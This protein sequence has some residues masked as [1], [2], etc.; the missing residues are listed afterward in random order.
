MKSII[1]QISLLIV[2]ISLLA[3]SK[4]STEPEQDQPIN[5]STKITT[6]MI[7]YS[8]TGGDAYTVIYTKEQPDTIVPNWHNLTVRYQKVDSIWGFVQTDSTWNVKFNKGGMFENY[9][10]YWFH[11]LIKKW[12]L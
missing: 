8:I 6:L 12:C 4:T 9:G 2:I 7:K 3:C 11:T 5:T 10:S 1:K